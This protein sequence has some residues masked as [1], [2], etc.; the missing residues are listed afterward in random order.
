[1]KRVLI[2]TICS[3]IFYVLLA[4]TIGS[5]VHTMQDLTEGFEARQLDDVLGKTVSWSNEITVDLNGI[6]IQDVREVTDNETGQT[7]TDVINETINSLPWLLLFIFTILW[8][9]YSIITRDRSKTFNI[10]ATKMTEFQETDEREIQITRDATKAA[11]KS[12]GILVPTLLVFVMVYP[13]VYK[14]LPEYPVYLLACTI[15]IPTLVYGIV[16]IKEYRK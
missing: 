3:V 16:W 11:Y 14:F 8:M 12:L 1:M 10:F 9:V 4:V 5:T 13:L 6:T 2:E 7:E 15:I